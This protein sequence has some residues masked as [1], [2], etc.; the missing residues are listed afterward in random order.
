MTRV[1]ANF[2]LGTRQSTVMAKFYGRFFI[3]LASLCIGA[4]CAEKLVKKEWW[5]TALVYQI[6][7]RGFQDS[8]G[9]GEGDLRGIINR[10]DYIKDLNVDA[11]WLNPIYLSPMVDS[12][13]D[14]V[15][16][17]SIHP[18][19]GNFD[20]F[21][22]L[23]KEAH[24]R[25]IKVILDLVPNHSSD[26]HEWFKKSVKYTRDYSDY[27][28]WADGSFDKNGRRVPPNNWVSTYSD[29]PGS[30]WTWESRR[31]QW[32][33]HKFHE[34]QPDLNL[35][36][37]NVLAELL[38]V[39]DFWL[40]RGVDGFRIGAVSYLFEDKALR[41]EPV[42]GSGDYT[43]GLPENTD[44]VYKFR[45]HIN[46]WILTRKSTPKLLVLESY[47]SHDKLIALY[48]NGTSVGV[49]PFNF[50]FISSIQNSS[51]AEQ[52]KNV[53]HDWLNMIPANAS[54]N[55]VLSNHDTSRAASRIGLNRVDGLHMLSLLLPGQ[56]YTYYGEEIAML[57]RELSWSE[58]I[59]P[60]GRSRTKETYQKYSRDPARTPMQWNIDRSAGFSNST[61]TYLPV[62]QEY[63]SRN[64]ESQRQEPQSNLNTYQQLSALRKDEVFT[65]GGYEL[66]TLNNDRVF[67]LKRFLK[68][69]PSYIVVVNLG[70]R[71]ENVN[72]TT[73]YPKIEAS[74]D[75]VVASSNAV[76]FTKAIPTE[77]LILSANAAYVLKVEDRKDTTETPGSSTSKKPGHNSAGNSMAMLQLLITTVVATMLFK[78]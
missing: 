47:D 74:M 63:R 29:E 28:I 12:G 70:L 2:S 38:N 71:E 56:A 64:V 1:A 34:C 17:D 67:V 24:D 50:R 61:T 73:L 60:M 37:E 4:Q 13:Y 55:W 59:D 26:Q 6:W 11:I 9:D 23:V 44:F 51:T 30:A 15:K 33:Y 53:L 31:R 78:Y 42:V 68:G 40:D 32:Y 16:Y 3:V 36:N 14:I 57:N 75:V 35:R 46:Q 72:L 48:G 18:L 8:D 21:D 39:T 69:H 76:S 10:L 43:S 19:F 20:D 41:D 25:G 77:K 45:S 52:I 62:H 27:Y 7:P 22:L 66:D 65:H 5:E 58:T 49:P 54:T